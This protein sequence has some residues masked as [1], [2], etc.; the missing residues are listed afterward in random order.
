MNTPVLLLIFNRPQTTK[1]V[2][3]CIRQAAP[4]Q[5]F[6]AADGPRTTR[7]GE[8]ALCDECRAIV[9]KIDW[10]CTVKTLF[11]DNNLGCGKSVSQ[12]LTWFF[13]Q[14]EEGIILEDDILPHPDFFPYCEILLEKYRHDTRIGFISGKNYR[15]EYV[16]TNDSYYFSA[17][18]HVWGW[19]GWRRT[20]ENYDF[21]L[22]NTSLKEYEA[23]LPFYY[24]D[25][26]A[27]RWCKIVFHRMK[28]GLIDTW[29]YQLG[30]SLYLKH[31]L[32]IIPSKNLVEN[33][34]FGADAT[35]TRKSDQRISSCPVSAIL[36][37]T[38]PKEVT[39]NK[40]ADMSHLL[41]YERKRLTVF[42]YYRKYVKILLKKKRS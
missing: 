30:I 3:E 8:A 15:P 6:I 11:R 10:P 17:Y 23:A 27:F 2:F 33:I 24:D 21:E 32:S 35:H 5:L 29:D 12:A 14:V 31:Y 20:W 41:D 39:Q 7:I 40:E 19:A 18:S 16:A 26:R 9:Q 22:K 13:E 36:P 34:G 37:L 4:K 1:R 42:D 28:H 25:E 38:H